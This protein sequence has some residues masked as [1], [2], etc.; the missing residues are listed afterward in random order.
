MPKLPASLE[1]STVVKALRST[2]SGPE[3]VEYDQYVT[4]HIRRTGQA[5]QASDIAQA[6]LVLAIAWVAFLLTAALVEHW[7]VPRGFSSLARYLLFGL[8]TAAT[9]RFAQLR[10]WPLLTGRINPLYT[11]RT[12]EQS[13]PSLKNSLINLLTLRGGDRP[14]SAAVLT[15][16]EQQ[17]AEGI[18]HA[19]EEAVVDRSRL[20]R[21]ASVL[22]TLV[23][24]T[25]AYALLSVKDPFTTAVRIAAPWAA[26][27]PPSRVRVSNV[28]PGTTTLVEGQSLDVEAWVEG[29]DEDEAAELVLTSFDGQRVD[30]RVPLTFDEELGRHVV[31]IPTIAK[32][33]Q[34]AGLSGKANYHIEAGD[35]RSVSY[36]VTVLPAPTLVVSGV[37]YQFPAYT[38]LLD[39][40]QEDT[41]DLRG[42]EDTR[43]TLHAVA[44]SLIES[45]SVDFEGDGSYDLEMQVEGDRATVSFDLALR[46]DR[47]TPKQTS[48][49]LRLK[50]P[51]GL[52]NAKPAK[53]RIEVYPDYPPEVELTLPEEQ[54][55][56]V[57]LNETVVI[58]GVAR[59]PD[60]ALSELRLFG[61]CGGE[62]VMHKRLVKRP[63]RGKH[64]AE[65]RFTPTEFGLQ[66]GD[67]M[68]YWLEASDNR[69]PDPQ[70]AV[71]ERQSFRIDSPRSRDRNQGE[72]AENS[73][74]DP[75]GQQ[76]E[77]GQAG[78]QGQEQGQEGEPGQE[79]EQ[80]G[81]QSQEGDQ[82]QEGEE[83]QQGEQ[84]QEGEQGQQGESSSESSDEQGG[85]QQQ[86][87]GE[88]GTDSQGNSSDESGDSK[89]TDQPQNGAS[90]DSTKSSEENSNGSNSG[91]NSGEASGENSQKQRNGASRNDSGA[92]GNAKGAADNEQAAG[93]GAE[94]KPV[95]SSGADD[96]EAFDRILDHMEKNPQEQPGEGKNKD[97]VNQDHAADQRGQG[98]SSEGR[99]ADTK[100]GDLTQER[101]TKQPGQEPSD[102]A[103]GGKQRNMKGDPSASDFE[104]EPKG[105]P[106]TDT[107]RRPTKKATQEPNGQEKRDQPEPPTA[108]AK[109]AK[110]ETVHQSSEPGDRPGGGDEG[111]GNRSQ[112]QGTGSSGENTAADEGAGRAADR[113]QG[114]AG[115][116]AGTDQP[117]DKPTG[118]PGE[119]SGDGSTQRESAGDKPGG[120]TPSDAG[121]EADPSKRDATPGD[122]PAGQQGADSAQAQPNSQP[123][124]PSDPSQQEPQPNE[125]SEQPDS[126]EP[127]DSQPGDEL[128]TESQ[129]S[130]ARSTAGGDVGGDEANLEF[131]RKKTDLV[132]DQLA[133]QLD[134]Q[135]V[136]EEL[137][138]RLGWNEADLRRFVER[139]KQRKAAAE[140]PDA[141]NSAKAQ[142]D[143]ALKA[144][145]L[146]P[147]DL[148]GQTA[149]DADQL[150]NQASGRTGRTPQKF[151]ER[152]QRYNQGVSEAA[153]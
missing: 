145:G 18:A 77:N 62:R 74:G 83:G 142:L 55:R 22:L 65:Y 46:A 5:V 4:S 106:S 39:Y 33:G 56:D 80:S 139:W 99:G 31:S 113:G 69:R 95:D 129:S 79:G 126:G 19:P 148:S 100:G 121:G 91:G 52:A 30:D 133:D 49:V 88:Q 152:L 11:A 72:L 44:N 143:A 16:L 7:I 12:I 50:T 59:D 48:Y 47:T 67:Q 78:Q 14:L 118:S 136:D 45:A 98:G 144:L 90:S 26:I 17:A 89:A 107:E 147:G 58:R 110:N 85:E 63:V 24:V 140:R 115:E 122:D 130:G 71:S 137:L 21:M 23:V 132:L 123:G 117:S 34:P 13:A 150:R 20:V 76:G 138:D 146:R 151:R 112:R 36:E 61:E 81:E 38:G 3:V 119:K 86:E 66:S 82:G 1:R 87:S 96:G 41:G 127:S 42:I 29:L 32:R 53:H 60:F 135:Q 109:T 70:V 68:E 102:K 28:T 105:S 92:G 94:S 93:S 9:L 116:K 114:E 131:A 64:T 149:R 108:G 51:D 35:G 54:E 128:G 10:L 120:E 57:R 111:D 43:V 25:A 15:T 40:T 125:S 103:P 84:G 124:Q 73:Q 27:A 104:G 141:R 97:T 75:D 6:L 153:E 134:K 37:D 8:A 101:D 2:D